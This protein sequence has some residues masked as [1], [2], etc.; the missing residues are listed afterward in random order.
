MIS[1]SEY[2]VDNFI[3]SMLLLTCLCTF[4]PWS[5]LYALHHL[6]LSFASSFQQLFVTRKRR[7]SQ[8]SCKYVDSSGIL[9][10]DIPTTL[11][12]TL[13]TASTLVI[14]FFG[15][16]YTFQTKLIYPASFPEGSRQVVNTPDQFGMDNWEDVTIQSADGVRIRLYAI[17]ASQ[18][19]GTVLYLHANAGNMGHRLPLARYFVHKMHCNVVMLSYRGYGLSEGSPEESGMK[20]DADA[21]L[22][23]V[24]SH[25]GFSKVPLMVY[26]QS[27]GGAVAIYLA[28]KYN[29]DV[30]ALLIENTFLSMRKLIPSVMP[31]LSPVTFLCHQTWES[32]ATMQRLSTMEKRMPILLLA[33]AQDE[34]VPP[35]HMKGLYNIVKDNPKVVWREFPNGTHNDTCVQEG[36]WN[37][38]ATFVDDVL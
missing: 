27:I 6:Y 35:T 29:K 30:R 32:E 10:M 33:G 24:Q 15:L 37:N 23:Y 28:N 5:G 2:A 36:Y 13:G 4:R 9:M 8:T 21:A 31:F 1:A 11:K 16:L 20:L 3:P 12:Y 14:A 7:D 34:L 38:V 22:E 19:R 17:H 26:G 18:A 25:K